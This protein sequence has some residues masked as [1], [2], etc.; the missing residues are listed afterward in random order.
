MKFSGNLISY[1]L[2]RIPLFHQPYIAVHAAWF[3]LHEQ[4]LPKNV[5]K[6]KVATLFSLVNSA[7]R[8]P[9]TDN[10]SVAS[11]FSLSTFDVEFPVTLSLLRLLLRLRL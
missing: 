2:G 9:T 8:S 3:P 5:L 10:P 6:S 7:L 1:F 4:Q 11:S